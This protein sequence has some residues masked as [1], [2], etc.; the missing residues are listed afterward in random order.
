MYPVP[1]FLPEQQNGSLTWAISSRRFC[2]MV[3]ASLA[4][5]ARSTRPRIKII[6]PVS[7][8]KFRVLH[9]EF[10]SKLE[11]GNLKLKNGPVAQLA[12][13]HP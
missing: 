1:L 7:S 6:K 8:F 4:G 9:Y 13:A 11:T 2:M 5:N 10:F 3:L 12:R